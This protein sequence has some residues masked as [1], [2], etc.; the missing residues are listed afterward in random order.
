MH[1]EKGFSSEKPKISFIWSSSDS[2]NLLKLHLDQLC[3]KL[4][5]TFLF[6]IEFTFVVLR[7]SVTV[8]EHKCTFTFDSKQSYFFTAC[9]TSFLIQLFPFDWGVSLETQ[10]FNLFGQFYFFIWRRNVGFVGLFALAFYNWL[11]FPLN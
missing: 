2:L 6:V 5:L 4:L 8:A 3:F 10:G 1:K 7:Q 11:I 9:K